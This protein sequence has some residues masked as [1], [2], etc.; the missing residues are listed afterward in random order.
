[1]LALPRLLSAFEK[2]L[3]EIK[4]PRESVLIVNVF[5]DDIEREVIESA[6]APNRQP[7]QDD[8]ADRKDRAEQQASAE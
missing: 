7:E 6:K 1:M 5:L 8:V 4:Q 3:D 2:V